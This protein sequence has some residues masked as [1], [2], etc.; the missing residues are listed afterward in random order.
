MIGAPDMINFD[1][2]H[3]IYMVSFMNSSSQVNSSFA[4]LSL[5]EKGSYLAGLWEGDGHIMSPSF[6]NKGCQSNTPCLAIT[7]SII[8]LP[9]FEVFK[10]HLGGWIRYKKKENAIVWT[11]TAQADLQK[12]VSLING[13]IRSPKLYQFNLLVDYLNKIFPDA[14]LVKHS[15]DCSDFSD[16]S[17]LAGFIDADGYFKIRYTKGSVNEQTGRRTKER[18]GLSFKI[19]QRKFHKFTNEAFEPLM[20]DIANFFTVR[21]ATTKHNDGVEYWCVEVNSFVRIETILYYLSTHALWTTK[22]NNYEDFCKAF[23]L[24]RQNGHLTAEGKKT[25]IHLKN[26]MNRKRTVFNWMHL[27]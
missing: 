15:V 5:K 26:C 19:E 24:V 11:V 2:S 16:N 18:I 17:W 20:K 14:T 25:I 22:R 7:A 12:V 23:Y 21:L 4:K 27:N 10:S 9:L 1:V 6:D 3:L 8:E 13:H